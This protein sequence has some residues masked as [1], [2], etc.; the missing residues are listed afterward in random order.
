[1]EGSGTFTGGS[2]WAGIGAATRAVDSQDSDLDFTCEGA[3][4]ADT[5]VLE[6]SGEAGTGGVSDTVEISVSDEATVSGKSLRG[7]SAGSE[8][9]LSGGSSGVAFVG[10][11]SGGTT[12]LA[13]GL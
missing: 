8:A 12:A 10:E 9:N 13:P 7:D 11:G 6:E 1:M 3:A 5:E 2:S 4:P